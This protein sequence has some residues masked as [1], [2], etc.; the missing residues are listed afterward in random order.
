MKKYCISGYLHSAYTFGLESHVVESGIYNGAMVPPA[1]LLA[2]IQKGLQYTEAELC[3]GEDG[4]EKTISEPLSLIE[5]VTPDVVAVKVKNNAAAVSLLASNGKEEVVVTNGPST[6]K[7]ENSAM[8]DGSPT[9]H[10]GKHGKINNFPSSDGLSLKRFGGTMSNGDGIILN[11]PPSRNDDEGME[12]DGESYPGG[13]C[14][15]PNNNNNNNNPVIP[16]LEIS[17]DRVTYLKGHDS[18]VFICA[19]NPKN[20][21]LASG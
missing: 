9:S 15:G 21:Y 16:P 8:D 20:D 14:G 18:E 1:A 10:F 12:M 13:Q 17:R 2:L 7:D 5:A 6:S 4:T 11:G 19:W 3:I